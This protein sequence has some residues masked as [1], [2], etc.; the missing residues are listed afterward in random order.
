MRDNVHNSENITRAVS[1]EYFK[2]IEGY[3]EYNL[4]YSGGG[5]TVLVFDKKEQAVEFARKLTYRAMR[6][7]DGMEIFAKVMEYDEKKTPGEYGY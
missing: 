7:F 6:N 1:E 5:H 4:V 2:D 3:S